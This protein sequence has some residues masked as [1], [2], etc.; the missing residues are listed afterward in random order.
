MIIILV[1]LLQNYNNL[2][3]MNVVESD[4]PYWTVN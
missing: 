1:I 4:I 3:V 2:N